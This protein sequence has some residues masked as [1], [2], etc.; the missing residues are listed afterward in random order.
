MARLFKACWPPW[1]RDDGIVS[2]GEEGRHHFFPSR[3]FLSTHEAYSL[4]L[5]YRSQDRLESLNRI[6]ILLCF[7]P[8]SRSRW[9]GAHGTVISEHFHMRS[10]NEERIVTTPFDM[11]VRNG[12]S[13]Y[14]LCKLAM[15]FAPH[16]RALAL[17]LFGVCD[18]MLAR[19]H[20][21]VCEELQDLPEIREWTWSSVSGRQK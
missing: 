15:E 12:V 1:G 21:S 19:H 7:F 20:T 4:R 6:T 3:A 5:T 17:P 2:A 9:P 18:A 8:L 13:R 10:S 16:V 11:V 14:Y